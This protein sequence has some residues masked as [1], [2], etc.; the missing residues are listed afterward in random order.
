MKKGII[1]KIYFVIVLLGGLALGFYTHQ[2]FGQSARTHAYIMSRY[3][4]LSSECEDKRFLTQSDLEGLPAYV[5][6]NYTDS[7]RQGNKIVEKR[8]NDFLVL[9][10]SSIGL[11]ITGIIGIISTKVQKRDK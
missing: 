6:E 9:L 5:V 1:L 8:M 10:C 2:S 4:T 11:S 7:V 3:L